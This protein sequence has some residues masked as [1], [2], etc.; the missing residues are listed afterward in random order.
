MSDLFAD[1]QRNE[2]RLRQIHDYIRHTLQLF[3]AWFGF[4]AGILT[5]KT[6]GDGFA[7]STRAANRASIPTARPPPLI[8]RAPTSKWL[9]A[10]SYRSGP[11][12]IFRP[13]AISGDWT[14]R[15]YARWDRGERSPSQKPS[16]LMTCPCGEMFDSHRLEH[17][18]IHVPHITAAHVAD[19]IRR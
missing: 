15:K 19:G 3:L 11:R 2:N 6:L 9:G 18:V 13:G 10:Y 12:L 4:F 5:M 1:D 7:V 8:R 17:T 14:E 16:S